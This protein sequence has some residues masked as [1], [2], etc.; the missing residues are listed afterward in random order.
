VPPFIVPTNQAEH[1]VPKTTTPK[2]GFIFSSK[3]SFYKPNFTGKKKIF[4]FHNKFV[5]HD[6]PQVSSSEKNASQTTSP[7]LRNL[8]PGGKNQA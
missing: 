6:W 3:L 7:E 4:S 8:K 1:S 5:L 2:K